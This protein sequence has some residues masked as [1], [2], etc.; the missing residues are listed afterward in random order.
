MCCARTLCLQALAD[1][2]LDAGVLMRYETAMRPEELRW[3]AWYDGQRTKVRASLAVLERKWM[4][5]L[6]GPI[7]MGVIA[8]GC[9]LGY[10]DFRFPEDVWRTEYPVLAVWY[11][12]FSKRPSMQATWPDPVI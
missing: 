1:A 7:D 4:E 6:N 10:L 2:I 12:E 11:E 5:H 9:A 3:P 8:V